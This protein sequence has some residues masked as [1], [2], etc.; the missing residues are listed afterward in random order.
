MGPFV[1]RRGGVAMRLGEAEAT[2]LRRVVGDLRAEI[3]APGRPDHMHRLFPP[4]YTEDSEAQAEFAR[5]TGEDLAEQKRAAL[6]AVERALGRGKVRR[7]LWTTDLADDDVSALLGVLNDARLTIGTR[8]GVT[9]E[10]GDQPIDQSD[11]EA[12]AKTVYLYLGWLQ[13]F[14]VDEL[15]A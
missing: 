2:L 9:E 7:G 3:D 6:D 8:L 15:L 13:S 14:L 12:F 10:M 4:A 5:L 1:R 11:P